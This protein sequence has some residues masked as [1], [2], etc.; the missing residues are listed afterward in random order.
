MKTDLAIGHHL[1]S[2]I[3]EANTEKQIYQSLPRHFQGIVNNALQC[4]YL[5]CGDFAEAGKCP[6][7]RS[8]GTITD[9]DVGSTED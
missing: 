9:Q 8:R 2:I 7:A 6:G 1:Y 4:S 3:E 5:A